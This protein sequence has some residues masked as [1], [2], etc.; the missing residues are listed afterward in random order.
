MD[1]YWY[2]FNKQLRSIHVYLQ[3]YIK[4]ILKDKKINPSINCLYIFK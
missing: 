3:T 4:N 2:K 1:Y